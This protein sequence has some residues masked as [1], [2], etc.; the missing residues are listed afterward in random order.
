M[1]VFSYIF[2]QVLLSIANKD[3]LL[4]FPREYRNFLYLAKIGTCFATYLLLVTRLLA[5]GWNSLAQ[6]YLELVVLIAESRSADFLKQCRIILQY[7]F[8]T[9]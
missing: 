4:L 9:Y 8:Q 3:T 5:F 7:N 1:E 6:S 2:C